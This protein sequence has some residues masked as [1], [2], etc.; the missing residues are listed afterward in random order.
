MHAV[1]VVWSFSSGR[2]SQSCRSSTV[3]SATRM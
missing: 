1:A 3:G 2:L